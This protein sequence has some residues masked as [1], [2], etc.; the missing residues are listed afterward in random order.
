MITIEID[1]EVY[2]KIKE[3]AIPF[4]ET[5]PNLVL[6]RAL[7][8]SNEKLVSSGFSR[9]AELN[10]SIDV[11]K[12]E[13][14]RHRTTPVVNKPNDLAEVENYSYTEKIERL[15][16][17][18]PDTHS[19]FLTFLMDKYW[20]TNGNYTVKQISEFM[21][22]MNLKSYSERLRN[23]WMKKP[24]KNETSCLRT[25]EHFRQTRKF[26]CWNGRNL[27]TNCDAVNECPYHP[28][29]NTANKNKC[30]LRNG[31]I[32]KRNN[33]KS[34]FQYGANYIDVIKNQHLKDKLI[35][36]E[37]MLAVFYPHEEYTEKLIDKFQSAFH[38]SDAEM[39]TLFE[40]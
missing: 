13:P 6:R 5:T 4:V 15:R 21:E 24:Y 29:S 38:F 37:P 17:A 2:E 20:N 25:I 30:D 14:K 8:L 22:K 28:D 16:L 3:I 40:I 11:R 27:K 19:A 1:N 18:S 7:G 36:L 12:K 35:P 39:E 9:E 34:P 31:V 33:P 32:W 10:P 26:G 23:P